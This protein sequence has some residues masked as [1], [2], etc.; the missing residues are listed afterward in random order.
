MSA[1]V[2]LPRRAHAQPVPH[3]AAVGDCGACVLGGVLGLDVA[4][5]YE[6]LDHD[7][8]KH[9]LGWYEIQRALRFLEATGAI[10][11]ILAEAPVWPHAQPAGSCEWGFTSWWQQGPWWDYVCTAIDAGLYGLAKVRH[12]RTGPL[13]AGGDHWVL[14]CG[15][16]D[17]RRGKTE[18]LVSCS[19]RHPAGA[20]IDRATF[21][22]ELGGFNALFARPMGARDR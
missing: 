22:R 15:Y 5:V 6:R 18:L 2:I 9:S 17:D 21:V 11:R 12:D 13:S 1:E 4:A 3:L 19:A 20:W 16:R 7:P 8:K 14:L 10:D